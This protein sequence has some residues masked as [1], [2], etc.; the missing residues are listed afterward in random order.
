[1]ET[2]TTKRKRTCDGA[3]RFKRIR[4]EAHKMPYSDITILTDGRSVEPKLFPIENLR[5]RIAK[6]N[7]A[8]GKLFCDPCSRVTPHS[9]IWRRSFPVNENV[10]VVYN[11]QGQIVEIS[12]VAS[13]STPLVDM[14]LNMVWTEADIMFQFVVI[15]PQN[16]LETVIQGTHRTTLNCRKAAIMAQSSLPRDGAELMWLLETHF[17]SQD[18][19]MPPSSYASDKNMLELICGYLDDNVVGPDKR[20]PIRKI[21]PLEFK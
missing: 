8:Y 6:T 20:S 18:G 13:K 11:T 16:K 7:N 10:T 3:E 5:R 17:G 1:M 14:S 9:C 21:Y 4:L 2:S 12:H 19:H 15:F